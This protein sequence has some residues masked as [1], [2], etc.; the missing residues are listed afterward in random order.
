MAPSSA[1]YLSLPDAPIP[2]K[3]TNASNAADA[4]IPVATTV[5]SNAS[6]PPNA[7]IPAN[8]AVPTDASNARGGTGIA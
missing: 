7:T 1:S 2:R 3:T 6:V 5:P 8:T 4:S